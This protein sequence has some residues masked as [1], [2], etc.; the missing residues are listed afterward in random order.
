MQSPMSPAPEYEFT[1]VQNGLIGDLAAKMKFVGTLF[2]GMGAVVPLA[3][4]IQYRAAG[5]VASLPF[6]IAGIAAI[7]VGLWTRGASSRFQDIVDTEG[8]DIANLMV[9]L[10]ELRRVYA[11]QRVVIGVTAVGILVALQLYLTFMS[12]H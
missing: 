4:V 3:H 9:A 12:S 10:E 2:I 7:V 8:N 1:A 11:L 6:V 5:I